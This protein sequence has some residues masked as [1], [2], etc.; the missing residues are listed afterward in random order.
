MWFVRA[1]Y[2]GKVPLRELRVARVDRP[3]G[4]RHLFVDAHADPGQKDALAAIFGGE[5]IPTEAHIQYGDGD[6][7]LSA[8][9][10]PHFALDLKVEASEEG[11]PRVVADHH[12][13]EPAWE[14]DATDGWVS[15]DEERVPLRH[16]LYAD[17]EYTNEGPTQAA[18]KAVKEARRVP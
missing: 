3:D 10:P 12:S 6:G 7:R 2:R 13:G 16:G 15:E 17:F 5:G 18:A 8:L 14:A 11:P 4:R 1:G 9:V